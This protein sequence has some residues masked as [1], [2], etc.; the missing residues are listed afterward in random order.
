MLGLSKRLL[1]INYHRV[2]SEPEPL[3]ENEITAADFAMQIAV[4]ARFFHVMPLS[5]A[6]T[7]LREGTIPRRAIA[8]TFDDGY[9]DNVTVALPLLLRAGVPAT[10]FI[11]TGFLDGG[12]MWNDSITDIIAVAR[13]ASLDLR[14]LDLGILDISS[15]AARKQTLATVLAQWKYLSPEERDRKVSELVSLARVTL[16]PS[17]MMSTEQV[18]ELAGA[19]M[20]IG[21][22]TLKHPILA[23]LP[24]EEARHEIA[25]SK[26]E[27]ERITGREV[28]GFA[29][30]N[31]RP[32]RDFTDEHRQMV[33]DCGYRFAVTTEYAAAAIAAD[34]LTLP[35]IATWDRRA[36]RFLP[37]MLGFF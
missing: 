1:I 20:S 33:A 12:R 29:Y 35:R 25:T 5:Y 18:R 34:P 3:R 19:G 32:Q 31:G 23:R 27:L 2:L 37:R 6:V 22:H 21:A 8:I 14:P 13:G 26:R 36:S 24:S 17:T 11:T 30:P 7:A 15:V 16:R 4:L 28:A 9:A 10:F